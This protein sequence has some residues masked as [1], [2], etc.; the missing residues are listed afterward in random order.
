MRIKK[1]DRHNIGW[2]STII[3]IP[4]TIH[5]IRMCPICGMLHV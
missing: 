3:Y 2:E 1:P 5:Y 4:Y